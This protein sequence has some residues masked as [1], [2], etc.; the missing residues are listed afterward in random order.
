M[1]NPSTVSEA[2]VS[3]TRKGGLDDFAT[4]FFSM[5]TA[6]FS[7]ISEPRVGIA[8]SWF[9]LDPASSAPLI[10]PRAAP[11]SAP[12]PEFGGFHRLQSSTSD[13]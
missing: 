5:S 11:I 9:L 10:P 1:V 8:G 13:V 2:A 6:I 7:N 3:P 12:V 4:L